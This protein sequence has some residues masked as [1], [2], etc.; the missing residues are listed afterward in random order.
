MRSITVSEQGPAKRHPQTHPT[1]PSAIYIP[2]RKSK[3]FPTS[4]RHIELDPKVST[5]SAGVV[6][7][8]E[9]DAADRLDLP[10]DA[11]NGRRGQEA[12]VTDY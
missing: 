12:V 1:H 3:S 2:L 6:T 8:G 11:G 9:D 5:R 4:I 10:D 7:C